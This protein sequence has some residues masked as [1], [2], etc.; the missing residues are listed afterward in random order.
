MGLDAFVF[1][2]KKNL[3]FDADALGAEFDPATGEYFFSDRE[4]DRKYPLDVRR[5]VEKRIGNIAAVSE[6]RQ[7]AR[8]VLSE[9][10]VVLSKVLYSGSHCGDA[11]DSQFLPSLERELT[12]LDRFAHERRLADMKEF[13]T[14]MR[15]LVVAAKVE[16]NPIVF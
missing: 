2:S 11:I 7:E 8:R 15:E 12:L 1:R 13:V 10:S 6:L 3:P 9:A 4:L 5:A 16:G 14:A